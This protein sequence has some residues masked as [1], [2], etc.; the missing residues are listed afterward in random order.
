[1]GGALHGESEAPVFIRDGAVQ[2]LKALEAQKLPSMLRFT[3]NSGGCSGYSY[4]FKLVAESDRADD[5]VLVERDGAKLVVDNVSLAFLEEAEVDYVEE[6]IR[7]SFQVV[8]N[9]LADSKCGCG[10][11]FNVA[12]F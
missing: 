12:S 10:V 11:S 2:K 8:K 9:N 1:M 7:S 3:V 5:D 4:E 6:M